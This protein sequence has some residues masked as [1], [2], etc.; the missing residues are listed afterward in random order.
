MKDLVYTGDF[1]SVTLDAIPEDSSTDKGVDPT[2]NVDSPDIG[3]KDRDEDMSGE[4]DTTGD[5]DMTGDQDTTGDQDIGGDTEEDMSGNEGMGEGDKNRG[6]PP[7]DLSQGRGFIVYVK[8][9]KTFTVDIDDPSKG[10]FKAVDHQESVVDP[11]RMM[12]YFVLNGKDLYRE[13][14]NL[15]MQEVTGSKNTS[16]QNNHNI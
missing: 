3:S 10:N 14:L 6:G 5:K 8:N 16:E 12:R 15:G 13:P 11:V 1:S 4:K 7:V 2:E 9:G